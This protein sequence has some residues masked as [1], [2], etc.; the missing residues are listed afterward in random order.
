MLCIGDA[1]RFG[2]LLSGFLPRF[3]GPIDIAWPVRGF[4]D[5]YVGVGDRD[6]FFKG[7][8]EAVARVADGFPD[9]ACTVR[10]FED[11]AHQMPRDPA[12]QAEIAEFARLAMEG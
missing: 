1:L 6:A 11:L 5:L 7:G 10:V 9:A 12:H 3:D 8:A 2:I 4:L